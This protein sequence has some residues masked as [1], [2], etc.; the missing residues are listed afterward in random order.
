MMVDA[1]NQC[2]THY[3]K[4]EPTNLLGAPLQRQG[5]SVYT[6]SCGK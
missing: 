4:W 6:H 5:K 1:E 3:K 2:I